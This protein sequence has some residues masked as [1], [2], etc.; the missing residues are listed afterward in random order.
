M[1]T[2]LDL[3]Q[4]VR[5]IRQGRDRGGDGSIDL[6]PNRI[7]LFGYSM[8]VMFAALEPG[9]QVA[10]LNSGGGSAADAL[11]WRAD[12]TVL[13]FLLA[14]RVPSLL[15]LTG[16]FDENYVSRDQP[17]KVNQI[18]GAIEIQDYLEQLEWAFWNGDPLA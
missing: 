5:A 13:G 11:R 8:G 15:N 6:D 14:L 4:L 12:K 3:M 7:S 18:R 10:A 17:V 1:Q 9:I 2:A 16:N